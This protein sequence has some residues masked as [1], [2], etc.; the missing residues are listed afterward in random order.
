MGVQGATGVVGRISGGIVMRKLFIITA[1]MALIFALLAGCQGQAKDRTEPPS[2]TGPLSLQISSPRE[3]WETS[4]GFVTVAG[5]VS[6]PQ[7]KVNVNGISVD[8]AEDG[9]FESDYILLNEG[10]NELRA[11]ATANGKTV[12]KIVTVN[13]TLKLHVSI[14][15][16]F[17]PSR[18]WFTESPAEIGGRVSDPRAEV[19]VNGKKAEVG[20][21]GMISVKLELAEG[22][23]QIDATAKLGN[24][25]ATDTRDAIYVPPPPLVLSAA[26]PEVGSEKSIDL[27][28]V[29]GIASDSDAIVT[30]NDIV[31]PVTAAGAFYA[32]LDLDE[33]ENE[34]AIIAVRGSDNVSRTLMVNYVPPA[35]TPTGT[36]ELRVTTPQSNTEYKEN[37]LPVTGMVDDPAT[38]VLVNGREAMVLAD[39]SFQGFAVLEEGENI[40]KVISLRDTLK[41]VKNIEVSFIPPLVVLLDGPLSTR[42]VDYSKE[43]ATFT[44]TVNKPEAKVTVDGKEVLVAPD[45]SFT[46]QVLLSESSSVKA[47]ATLGNER[48]EHYVLTGVGEKGAI[49]TVPG[50]SIFFVANLKH[51][52]AITLKAGETGRLPLT[53]DTRKDGPGRFYGSLTY[54]EEEYGKMPLAWPRGLDVYLEPPEFVAYANTIYDFNL[55]FETTEELDPGTYRLRF[56]RTFEGGLR[57]SG[58]IKVTVE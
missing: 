10:K 36:I 37:L 33:G 28:K 39:G 16:N 4:W 38:T 44:G 20:D 11:V 40:I 7:A 43:P 58:W 45:G 9:S 50:Y 53:L 18:D 22:K 1:L 41:V 31:A 19:I 13:Y 2:A 29:T 3:S 24:Q 25:V 12:S 47:V 26:L 30:V 46:A 27:V 42:G 52:N 15:L 49:L 6:P 14:S 32:Y 51:E 21:D 54:V 35:V 23:N 55:V 17:E 56:Y 34:I 5:I 48:D 8:V 57:G